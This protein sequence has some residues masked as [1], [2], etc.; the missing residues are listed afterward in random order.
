ML[1][2]DMQ[3]NHLCAASDNSGSSQLLMP[4]AARTFDGADDLLVVWDNGHVD[5]GDDISVMMLQNLAKSRQARDAVIKE[6]CVGLPSHYTEEQALRHCQDKDLLTRL[7]LINDRIRIVEGELVSCGRAYRLRLGDI[8]L[9]AP[10]QRWVLLVLSF[11]GA[12]GALMLARG[13]R[14]PK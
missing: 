9:C 3:R 7:A 11:V 4:C 6:I 5:N 13:R 10:A 8:V 1:Q 12:F 14:A 2:R